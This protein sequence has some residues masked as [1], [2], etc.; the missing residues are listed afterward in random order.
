M[1]TSEHTLQ[2]TTAVQLSPTN[3][4]CS[5]HKSSPT[6]ET[7]ASD[8]PRQLLATELNNSPMVADG[9]IGEANCQEHVAVEQGPA[10]DA[11][12]T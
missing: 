4:L 10:H 7:P 12:D 8:L 2:D 11:S 6:R 9:L 1:E 3:S 5:S